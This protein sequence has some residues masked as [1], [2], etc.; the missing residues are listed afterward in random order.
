MIICAVTLLA[1]KGLEAKAT[2]AGTTAAFSAV[3]VAEGKF[4]S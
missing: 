3:H 4:E 1:L 2:S